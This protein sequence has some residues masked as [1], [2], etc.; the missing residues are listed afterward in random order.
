EVKPKNKARR[1]TTTQMELL[2]AD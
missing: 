2:Y 1:R